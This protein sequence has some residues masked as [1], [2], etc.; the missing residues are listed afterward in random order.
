ML[1]SCCERRGGTEPSR[2]GNPHHGPQV[3]TYMR[4]FAQI[5][6]HKASV[7]RSQ[8]WYYK[9]LDAECSSLVGSASEGGVVLG[10][11]G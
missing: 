9:N 7:T 4:V 10:V 6:A 2:R 3:T 1:S 11:T 8:I 5:P